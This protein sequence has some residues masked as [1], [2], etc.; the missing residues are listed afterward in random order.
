M[1]YLKVPILNFD[2]YNIPKHTRASIEDYI[3]FGFDPGV[4]LKACFANDLLAA[5]TY[6]DAENRKAL[7][8]ICKWIY[9]HAPIVSQG[10]YDIVNAYMNRQLKR[11][12]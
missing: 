7:N 5:V 8:D 12:K 1:T 9:N 11:G 10:N 6:A 3:V 2:G 4:F